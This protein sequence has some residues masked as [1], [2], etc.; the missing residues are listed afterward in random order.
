MTEKLLA[1][2]A[3]AEWLALQSHAG[4]LLSERDEAR[5]AYDRMT[6]TAGAA[7]KR[8]S[9]LESALTGCLE[10]LEW[11]TPYGEQAWAAAAAALNRVGAS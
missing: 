3:I 7:Q 10:H 9:E 4:Q 8:I 5:A 2:I 1:T 11:S 6:A